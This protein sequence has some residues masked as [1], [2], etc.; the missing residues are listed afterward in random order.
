MCQPASTEPKKVVIVGAGPAGL[1]ASILLLRKNINQPT[2]KYHVTLVDPG[3]N[4]GKLDGDGLQAK[5]SWM[6]GLTVHG[7]EA[8]RKVP[9]LYE[10]YIRGLG[11]DIQH[12]VIGLSPKMK[13]EY[14]AKEFGIKDESGFVVDRNFICA[15][16]AR[17]LDEKH[18]NAEGQDIDP[19]VLS[20]FVSYY[21][22]KALFV[23]HEEKRVL[24]R[25]VG[26]S[27]EQ[28]YI[29]YDLV[30]GC[31]GIR[32]VVRNA[33]MSVD[34]NFEFD[35]RGTFGNNKAM[36]VDRP[37]NIKEGTFFFLN[38]AIPNMTSFTLPETGNKLNVNL[39]YSTGN[40]HNIDPILFTN[41]VDGISKYFQKHFYAFE[42]DWND[43]AKQWV[44]QGW[45]TIG[46]VHCNIYHNTKN[47]I[48]LIG[49]AA[50]ATSPSIG[51]GMNTALADAGVFDELLDKHKDD[52]T[53]AIQEFSKERVKEGNA[54]TDLSFYTFSLSGSQQLQI[55]IG[56]TIRRKLNKLL[57]SLFDMDP[58]DAVATG[59]KLSVTYDKMSKLGII[60]KVRRTNDNIMRK[61]FE[62][63]S[64]MVIEA[65]SYMG[66][67]RSGVMLGITALV[68]SY[69]YQAFYI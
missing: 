13:I 65:K 31:D 51:Q 66:V 59:S 53:A 56:Q 33:L 38:D 12:A 28:K 42:A 2:P 27:E 14:S 41:D 50:H 54:L 1:L 16:L 45:S 35:I 20:D 29:D 25:K 58:M 26:Q 52:I 46:Q 17:Y 23:D 39:G 7:L 49:D 61:H 68:V 47:M 24:I 19:S 67:I 10:D 69:G 9:G 18:D 30:I 60:Q 44:N 36:H 57:P 37:S 55:M 5:R 22:T 40:E 32:S 15:A 62:K 11:I 48:L 3:T 4:Y 64:G 6:I 63:T 8:I 21:D 43:A 34:R